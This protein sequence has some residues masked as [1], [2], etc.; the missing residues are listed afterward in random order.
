[1]A[2]QLTSRCCSILFGVG[3]LFMAN[4][5]LAQEAQLAEAGHEHHL[6]GATPPSKPQKTKA[7]AVKKKR[8]P[9]HQHKHSGGV[10]PGSGDH[11]DHSSTPHQHG[12]GTMQGFLGPYPMSREAS[13]T[14]WQPDG[15]P[16]EGVHAT[17]GDWM[18]MWHALINGV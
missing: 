8:A 17:V 7:P 10:V 4:A 6:H 3:F 11:S 9:V 14:S 15:T 18:V 16:H 12:A 1:M 5:A 2:F 13:G